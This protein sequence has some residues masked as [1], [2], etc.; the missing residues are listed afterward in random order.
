MPKLNPNLFAD[1]EYSVYLDRRQRRT[2]R[3]GGRQRP[4]PSKMEAELQEQSERFEHTSWHYV[5]SRYERGWLSRWAFS[6]SKAGLIMFG[7][8]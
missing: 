8:W 2:L 5:P 7:A 4:N 1:D 3:S 6:T